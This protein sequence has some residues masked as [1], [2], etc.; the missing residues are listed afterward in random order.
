M[1]TFSQKY[2]MLFSVKLPAFVG[3]Q[4]ATEA[5]EMFRKKHFVF[6]QLGDLVSV[7][8]EIVESKQGNKTIQQT[9]Y[10]LG[11]NE[12]FL[13][14]INISD[15]AIFDI[16]SIDLKGFPK[17]IFYFS[18]VENN[19]KLAVKKYLMQQQFVN[20]QFEQGKVPDNIKILT[21]NDSEIYSE[22]I[23]PNATVFSYDLS[24]FSN[25]FYKIISTFPKAT[26]NT[27]EQFYFSQSKIREAI[28]GII[29]INTID[30]SVF[31]KKDKD[32]FTFAFEGL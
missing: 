6:K 20:I 2:E 32:V 4:Q 30:N 7:I 22:K 21:L 19:T 25:G 27:T 26:D 24:K 5:K 17:Q 8:A 10:P 1:E 13:F 15:E 9:K 12:H 3:L 23:K 14:Q 18:N 29:D 11:K 16:K 31:D 28:L